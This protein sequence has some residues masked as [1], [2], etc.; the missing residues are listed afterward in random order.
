MTC[1]SAVILFGHGARDAAWAQPMERVRDRLR[2]Q[3]PEVGAELAFLEF[4]APTLDEAIDTLVARGARRIVV[5]PM[6]IA[7]GG[8]L[9]RDLP[10]LVAAACA[11]HPDREITQ[12]LAV[13]ESDA[14][15]DAMASYAQDCV[16]RGRGG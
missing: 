2:T 4:I 13:G 12:A 15:I 16:R 3:A 6:F 8:H 14:V 11:R 5:V 7:Q 1:D 10:Q 9:K